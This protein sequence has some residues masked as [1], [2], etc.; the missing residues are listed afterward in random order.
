MS[1]QAAAPAVVTP[2]SPAPVAQVEV[3]QPRK[4]GDIPRPSFAPK[5]APVVDPPKTITEAVTQAADEA[6]KPN[7]RA[8]L[9]ARLN[10]NLREVDKQKSALSEREKAIADKLDASERFAKARG[11][12]ESKRY[13]PALAELYPDLQPEEA[14]LA[15]LEEAAAIPP[16][17]LT[18]EDMERIAQEQVKA[19]REAEDKAKA[20]AAQA[21]L[22]AKEAEY[23]NVAMKAAEANADKFPYINAYDVPA[24]RILAVAYEIMNSTGNP[25]DVRAVL[26]AIEK[27]TKDRHEGISAK[28]SKLTPV[29]PA[30]QAQEAPI[31]SFG[32]TINDTGGVIVPPK[33]LTMSEREAQIKARLRA[34]IT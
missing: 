10:Q 30:L 29:K 24:S 3:V 17:Q 31:Q 9:I 12:V 21:G 32:G 19:A 28:L 14:A 6:G 8:E 18:A 25:P 5:P 1:D 22:K 20:E 27:E 34:M 23:Q 15:I 11:H 26:E 7:E 2:A 16:K 4:P 13:L 33:K